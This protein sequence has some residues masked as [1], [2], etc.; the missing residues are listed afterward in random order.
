MQP[1]TGT[2]PWIMPETMNAATVPDFPEV[3]SGRLYVQGMG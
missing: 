3:F 2:T 1:A